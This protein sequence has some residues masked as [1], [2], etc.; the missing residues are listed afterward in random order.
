MNPLISSVRKQKWPRDIGLTNFF[1]LKP[2]ST[3]RSAQ[4]NS[5]EVDFAV[6]AV[7]GALGIY[8]GVFLVADSAEIEE[9]LIKL[10]QSGQRIGAQI[11]VVKFK[12]HSKSSWAYCWLP[13]NAARASK[14]ILLRTPRIY[15]KSRRPI[16]VRRMIIVGLRYAGVGTEETHSTKYQRACQIIMI[17]YVRII[18]VVDALANNRN[19]MSDITQSDV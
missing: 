4:W 13:R 1:I 3:S 19:D 8:A 11:E 7:W 9:S 17:A 16:F 15:F 5:I 14:L 2:V 10:G 18:A 12:L 6:V